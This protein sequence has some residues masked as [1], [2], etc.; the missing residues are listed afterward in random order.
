[1]TSTVTWRFSDFKHQM[2]T[3]DIDDWI[4]ALKIFIE[5]LQ[6]TTDFSEIEEN[7]Q[8]FNII[9][10]KLDVDT[11]VISEPIKMH[12]CLQALLL[13]S[14]RIS[15]IALKNFLE[16]LLNRALGNQ[17][18]TLLS[19]YTLLITDIASALV[20]SKRNRQ[21]VYIEIT[22]KRCLEK[23]N[24]STSAENTITSPLSI[25]TSLI[26]KLGTLITNQ[27]F[28]NLYKKM[29][30]LIENANSN[31]ISEL[32]SLAKIWAIYANHD[33]LEKFIR[34]LINYVD[35]NSNEAF[36]VLS[37]LVTSLPEYFAPHIN[38]LAELFFQNI[39]SL[40]QKNN[41]GLEISSEELKNSQLSI[42]SLNA[43][44]NSFPK[45][46]AST[47]DVY[48]QVAFELIIFGVDTP[49]FAR[50]SEIQEFS[51]SEFEAP[52]DDFLDPDAELEDEDPWISVDSSFPIR[53]SIN[54]FSQTII[55]HYP[56][57]FLQ[58]FLENKSYQ[59]NSL[60]FVADPD[61]GSKMISLQTL[62]LFVRFCKEK[63]PEIVI[64][65]WIHSFINE[66]STPT[67]QIFPLLYS[68]F[69]EY[70]LEF[71]SYITKYSL[72]IVESIK[73]TQEYCQQN[74]TIQQQQAMI[75]SMLIL[76]NALISGASNIN[77]ISPIICNILISI[78]K[79]N[80]Q[81]NYQY[82]FYT[83]SLLL[84]RDNSKSINHLIDLNKKICEIA[85]SDSL[86]SI[87]TID[88]LSIYVSIFSKL[89]KDG[90]SKSLQII[91]SLAT[92]NVNYTKNV[93][94]AISLM[95]SSPSKKFLTPV[96][97]E[98][99]K[100]IQDNITSS[101]ADAS[102]LSKSLLAMYSCAQGENLFNQEQCKSIIPSIIS[103]F[104]FNDN[105]VRK[106]VVL[107]LKK[108]S[109]I[110]SVSTCLIPELKGLLNSNDIIT[111]Q[112]IEGVAEILENSK[113]KGLESVVTS[114]IE[115]GKKLALK[116]GSELNS[117][118]IA[119]FIGRIVSTRK[120]LREKVLNEFAKEI[121]NKEVTKINPFTV[122]CVG[123]IG[124]K[125][126]LIDNKSIVDRI[127]ELV[128][129]N[130]RLIFSA[131]VHSLGLL[132]ANNSALQVM[133]PQIVERTKKDTDHLSL[134]LNALAKCLK[135]RQRSSSD[136]KL[137][138]SDLFEQITKQ[139]E[140]TK[141]T[142]ATFVDIFNSILAL[143]P[144]LSTSF[145]DKISQ[146]NKASPMLSLA[147]AEYIE[148]SLHTDAEVKPILTKM[149]SYLDPSNPTVCTGA[150]SSVKN[151]IK[152]NKLL[153]VLTSN[154]TS[155][156]KCAEINDKQYLEVFYGSSSQKIDV[157]R[158]MRTIAL[159]SISSLF[160]LIPEKL[161]INQM[162]ISVTKATN[163]PLKEI[164]S[165]ALSF[166]IKACDNKITLPSILKHFV[167]VLK[168]TNIEKPVLGDL[169]ESYIQIIAKLRV[170]TKSSKVLAIE[171]I[172]A[173][174]PTKD[175]LQKFE[176]DFS[177][178]YQ[179]LNHSNKK[180]NTI[181][182]K[183]IC[184][185]LMNKYDKEFAELYVS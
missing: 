4:N 74:S 8:I 183:L 137:N 151:S 146:N 157:G 119:L 129:C 25:L 92:R 80:T 79:N 109:S 90:A 81:P 101:A 111:P 56:D 31:Y 72:Q 26:E 87:Y 55:K 38:K 83:S 103:L 184:H 64:K 76:F 122:R 52:E 162:I 116:P 75:P 175:L 39:D 65:N 30:A 164:Q 110:E 130:D 32:A 132:A 69:A 147:I 160:S 5:Y 180:D 43:L 133:L 19:N 10:E 47:V 126:S 36:F 145:F 50:S 102:L 154:F 28:T 16:K 117:S 6:S 176:E 66:I 57:I 128:L 108:L 155:I 161:D 171:Q 139:N 70:L 143:N 174:V 88:P 159:D 163:D 168:G 14:T 29:V 124:Y 106:L 35:K 86:S 153:P 44:I 150:I 49:V 169:Y 97:K 85:K 173:N 89:D 46:F 13:L 93:L 156:C 9:I 113:D 148:N 123:E 118:N 27:Q 115:D 7:E 48:C 167:P 107:V 131:A 104:S 61:S 63:I 127:F 134:W 166:I 59:C 1:M 112:I 45:Q 125:Y 68:S 170:L 136:E 78:S 41:E 105:R 73:K 34:D 177:Q 120:E 37:T 42:N 23:L 91:T 33:L 142:E 140:Y 152:Y 121:S 24:P 179:Q 149:I 71:P 58:T 54:L 3:T 94:S 2:Q 144:N 77:E 98:L 95:A 99:L 17:N 158:S 51:D 84:N 20:N 53:K 96:T 178:E 18:D 181:N 60:N 100:I 185:Q 15:I 172:A 182:S 62:L 67:Q 21:E 141:E 12:H 82:I 114:L 11:H 40:A 135:R 22:F 138:L 165:K